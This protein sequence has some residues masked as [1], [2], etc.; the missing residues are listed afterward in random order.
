ML[1]A[2]LTRSAM[3]RFQRITVFPHSVLANARLHGNATH[4][5]AVITLFLLLWFLGGGA[6]GQTPS[7][8]S[9]GPTTNPGDANQFATPTTQVPPASIPA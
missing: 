4:V 1:T 3:T 2:D 5:I 8:Y 9:Y 7:R 6:S